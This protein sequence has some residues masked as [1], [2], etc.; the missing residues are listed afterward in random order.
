MVMSLIACSCVTRQS[1]IDLI[2]SEHERDHRQGEACYNT[3][4]AN[5][6]PG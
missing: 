5:Y 4:R 2:I 3:L 6:Y 1:L